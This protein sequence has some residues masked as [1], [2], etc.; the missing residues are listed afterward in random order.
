VAL[1]R[2]QTTKVEQVVEL[3]SAPADESCADEP[4]DVG[5]PAYDVQILLDLV[6]HS[7]SS[8]MIP[9]GMDR[10]GHGQDGVSRRSFLVETGWLAADALAA[11]NG[12]DGGKTVETR[13]EALERSVAFTRS[14]SGHLS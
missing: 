14:V 12:D 11:N 8:R 2:A 1:K 13:V 7:A 4:V 9:V 6:G 3:T 10:C 5:L